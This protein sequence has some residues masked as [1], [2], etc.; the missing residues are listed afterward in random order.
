MSGENIMNVS[1]QQR[2]SAVPL[3]NSSGPDILQSNK[4]S[5]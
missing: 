1:Q 5:D 3:P 2:K 4:E